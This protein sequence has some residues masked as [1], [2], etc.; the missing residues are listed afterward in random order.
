M[1]HV[2]TWVG[3][4]RNCPIYGV[5]T[6]QSLQH[7]SSHFFHW[8]CLIFFFQLLFW[9]NRVGGF[10]LL[11]FSV[12]VNVFF[13]NSLFGEP[14][15][16]LITLWSAVCLLIRGL[17]YGHSNIKFAVSVLVACRDLVLDGI[18]HFRQKFI[19]AV[20]HCSMLYSDTNLSQCFR[21][22]QLKDKAGLRQMC[23]WEM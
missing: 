6:C 15:G 10:I 23:M 19:T 17:G 8:Q 9:D 1:T 13:L 7:V 12:I 5:Q 16:V 3:S 20:H 14:C 21:W 18:N 2:H 4:Q 22:L 11:S